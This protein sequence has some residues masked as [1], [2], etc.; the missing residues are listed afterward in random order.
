MDPETHLLKRLDIEISPALGSKTENGL[1]SVKAQIEYTTIRPQTKF[2]VDHFAWAPPDGATDLGVKKEKTAAA[3]QTLVGKPA[4]DFSLETL[5]GQSVSLADLK[6]QVVVLD[7]WATWC[8][9]CVRSLPE[10][11]QIYQ[12]K[13][14]EGIKVYAINLKETQQQ[15]QSFLQ[16]RSLSVPVL[17]DTD[18]EVAQKFG[19]HA[20]PQTIVIGKDGTV[21]KVF[22]GASPG[23]PDQIR[24]EIDSAAGVSTAAAE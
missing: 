17:L 7:F 2:G 4:P 13:T 3:P 10:L 21:R 9:P 15:V 18:G 14:G 19:I 5:D 1:Q 6:G 20:I 16:T 23:T 12:Q 8:G 24:A 22:I 11:D